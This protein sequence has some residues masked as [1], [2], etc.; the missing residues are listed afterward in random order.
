MTRQAETE[1][2]AVTVG[3]RI[4]EMR[5]KLGLDR[6]PVYEALGITRQDYNAKCTPVA[7]KNQWHLDELPALRAYFERV[8]NESLPEW[9]VLDEDQARL[10]AVVLRAARTAGPTVD[11]G[12]STDGGRQL[13]S[14]VPSPSAN[15]SK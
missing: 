14:L 3:R 1:R 2:F 5:V 11:G 9:P 13:R 10:L 12:K 6:R 8:A 4:E 15:G 7:R